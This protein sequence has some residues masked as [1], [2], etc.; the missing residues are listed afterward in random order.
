VE[1]AMR[2]P[3]AMRELKA[4]LEYLIKHNADHAGEIVE[5]ADRAKS[6]GKEEAYGHLMKGVDLLNGS[7]ESLS[8]ALLTLRG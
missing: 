6:L 2:E 3:D 5:L 7:N 4:L 8:S 1:E